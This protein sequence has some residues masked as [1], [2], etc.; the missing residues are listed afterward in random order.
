MSNETLA[1]LAAGRPLH[2]RVEVYAG[3]TAG[4]PDS[5]YTRTWES[6]TLQD[7]HQ[8]TEWLADRRTLAYE[9][10][11]R[12]PFPEVLHWYAVYAVWR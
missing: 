2:A 11:R 8:L 6:D 3:V 4:V 10:A 5:F 1:P 7:L 9:H 12:L